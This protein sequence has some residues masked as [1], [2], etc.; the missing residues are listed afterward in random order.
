MGNLLNIVTAGLDTIS[1]EHAIPDEWSHLRSGYVSIFNPTLSDCEGKLVISY[2]V[3]GEVDELRRIA[4]AVLDD[5][6]QIVPGSAT[7]FSDQIEFALPDGLDTDSHSWFADPRYFRLSDGLWMMWNNGHV[8]GVNKQ[9]LVKV[10]EDGL[11]PVG[12]AR[13]I[14]M[15][16]ARRKTE[17]NWSLFEDANGV[18]AVYSVTPHRI[19]K[20]DMS[21]DSVI[22]CRLAAES[23]WTA[24]YSK[25][26]GAL[27]GGAQPI[28]VGSHFFNLVHS[29]YNMPEGREYVAA[30]YQFEASY[31]FK[32]TQ[33]LP[34]PIFVPEV[35]KK[36]ELENLHDLNPGTSRVVYP[37]GLVLR[38][39]E[40][41]FSIGINDHEMGIARASLSVIQGE[42]TPVKKVD[43]TSYEYGAHKPVA[44]E[45][46][47]RSTDPA[48]P[49]F[50][51]NA[52]GQVLS[53]LTHEMKFNHGNFGDEAS[54]DIVAKLSGIKVRPVRAGDHKLLAIGSILHRMSPGDVVWGSGI[55]S[56]D[57]LDHIP[58]SDVELTAVRGPLTL[59]ALKRNGWDVSGI[60]E[61][62]DPGIL[63]A[64]LYAKELDA[65]DASRNDAYGPVRIIPHFRDEL[66]LRRNH[67]DWSASF[68]TVDCHP[69][70]M[71]KRLKGAEKVISSSLHGVIFAESLGIPAV[72]LASVGGEG[73]YKFLDYYASSGRTSVRACES[74]EEALM[75]Q[76]PELPKIE[77][78][79]W[80][81]TFPAESIRRLSMQAPAA[82]KR[83]FPPAETVPNPLFEIEWKK[84]SSRT[85]EGLWLSGNTSTIVLPRFRVSEQT[86]S[87]VLKVRPRRMIQSPAPQNLVV[88]SGDSVVNVQWR[89]GDVSIRYITLTPTSAEWEAGVNIR[90]DHDARAQKRT[91][92][93]RRPS[94]MRNLCIRKID[95][96]G[97]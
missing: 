51:W 2:R 56:P 71:L 80:L 20:V 26:Y 35:L 9:F 86:K 8:D 15:T 44:A 55:K 16:G 47:R 68:V 18:W 49:V 31:P 3:V 27:R 89:A 17:K 97:A 50:W 46:S 52:V 48:I 30:V 85:G 70:D 6:F 11:R 57:A 45:A 36:S 13:E 4:T 64:G 95:I 79:K 41:I 65:Y 53:P 33:E 22:T 1:P 67:P 82:P 88:T 94:V 66:V 42:M 92:R 34:T 90:F 21:S 39:D 78:Q 43:A 81:D 91:W 25:L 84:S 24:G 87:V 38:G 19:L 14:R 74:L 54:P 62:F 83:V 96:E 77:F 73:S 61:L 29:S 40:V 23:E 5:N 72:W 69:L 28:Q 58:V 63:L 60:T 59:E 10:S 37:S 12:K 75:A 32:P 7:S 93:N 76:A